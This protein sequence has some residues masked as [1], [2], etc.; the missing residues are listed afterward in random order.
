[1]AASP[2]TLLDW[3][4]LALVAMAIELQLLLAVAA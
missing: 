2:Q 3:L 4:A 1:M